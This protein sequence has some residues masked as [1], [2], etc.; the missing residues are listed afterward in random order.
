MEVD[1]QEYEWGVGWHAAIDPPHRWG[2][3]EEEARSWIARIEEDIDAGLYVV[4]RRPV[5]PWVRVP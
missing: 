4:I 2:M 3:S 1:E 5:G